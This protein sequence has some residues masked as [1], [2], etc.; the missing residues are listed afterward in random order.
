MVGFFSTK[1]NFIA[2]LRRKCV[3]RSAVVLVETHSFGIPFFPFPFSGGIGKHSS[4]GYDRKVQEYTEFLRKNNLAG[5]GQ[6]VRT[7]KWYAG[8]GMRRWDSEVEWGGP[9]KKGVDGSHGEAVLARQT[10][11]PCSNLFGCY[12]PQN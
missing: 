8:T 10:P 9:G 5:L 1:V 2:D 6:M 7:D 12:T 3:C 4:A 11:I